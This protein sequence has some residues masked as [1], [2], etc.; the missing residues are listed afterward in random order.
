MP[1]AT[2]PAQSSTGSGETTPS[3]SAT[4]TSYASSQPDY[5]SDDD[6]AVSD[7][8][9]SYLS[10]G[11]RSPSSVRTQLGAPGN[12]NDSHFAPSQGKGQSG[13]PTRGRP[14]AASGK[15]PVSRPAMSTTVSAPAVTSNPSSNKGTE[16]AN[17]RT[18][19]TTTTTTTTAPRRP[20]L[21]QV[22]DCTISY[23]RVLSA[24]SAS[25]ANGD[26]LDPGQK[27]DLRLRSYDTVR[28]LDR[29]NQINGDVGRKSAAQIGPV[30]WN[31]RE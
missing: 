21:R 17:R 10:F 27:Q 12:A 30:F 3:A 15:Q 18:Q 19:T 23:E 13:T 25:Q 11:S 31:K 5:A 6:T 16:A 2:D 29:A 20:P 8:G 24:D 1:L 9:M 4:G 22:G 7:L 26:I 28:A 14:S